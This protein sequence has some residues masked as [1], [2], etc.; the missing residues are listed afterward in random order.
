MP[1]NSE[2]IIGHLSVSS[3]NVCRYD[4]PTR[5]VPRKAVPTTPFYVCEGSSGLTRIIALC[6]RQTLCCFLS[7]ASRHPGETW[8]QSR[9]LGLPDSLFFSPS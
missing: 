2:C 5:L 8:L 4:K 9:N 7:V 3:P 6:P 1:L